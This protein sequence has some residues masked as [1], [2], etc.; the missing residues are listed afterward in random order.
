MRVGFPASTYVA[1]FAMPQLQHMV[2]ALSTSAT[3][4]SSAN[5]TG[6]YT[7]SYP[8]KD[9]IPAQRSMEAKEASSLL[10][11]AD[12]K[13]DIDG[14]MFEHVEHPPARSAPKLPPPHVYKYSIVS[15]TVRCAR[16]LPQVY[17]RAT[18]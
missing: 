2:L 18:S 12:A 14:S 17:R 3:P 7:P 4:A 8:S 16:G 9:Y 6:M 15:L 10:N 1:S 11:K 13:L 5:T